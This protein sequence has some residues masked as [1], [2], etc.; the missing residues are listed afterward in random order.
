MYIVFVQY[1]DQVKKV[2]EELNKIP[3]VRA[4]RFVGK[5][6]GVTQE[7]QKRT[8]ERF[9]NGEFNVLV[10]SSIGEEGLDI[11]AVDCVI[12]YE[13]IPSEIRNIQRRG[14][15]A[16]TRPGEVIILITKNTR[17]E[18]YYWV[19]RSRERKMKRVV[20]GMQKM[21]QDRRKGAQSKLTE[22]V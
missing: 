5:R 20:R 6:E 9:R 7:E 4:E 11:P 15:T 18:A 13:P 8:I 2:V 17:D 14:R 1:R 12:F 19:A 22:F 16:R 3:G 10:A 21:L